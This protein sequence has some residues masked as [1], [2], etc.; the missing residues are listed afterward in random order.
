MKLLRKCAMT[1]TVMCAASSATAQYY[2]YAAP[3]TLAA[4]PAQMRR[5]AYQ[6]GHYVPSAIPEA[7]GAPVPPPQAHHA[8]PV[9]DQAMGAPEGCATCNGGTGYYG[10]DFGACGDCCG[11]SWYAGFTALY[12]TRNKPN[13]YQ[14]SFDT[15]NPVGELILNVDTIDD[16]WQE[17]FE[18]RVGKYIGCNSAIELS[19]WTLDNFGGTATAADPPGVGSLNTPFDFRSLNFNGTPV[20]DLFDNSQAHRLTRNDEFHNI[21]VNFVHFPMVCNPCGRMQA[22]WFAGVRYINFRESWEFATSDNDPSFGVDP[23]GEAAYDIDVDNNLF[24]LQVGG[25]GSFN[26]TDCLSVYAAPRFGVFANYMEH[27]SRIDSGDGI[28]A[29]SISSD[30]TICSLLGQLDVGVNYQ[31]TQRLSVFGGYRVLAIS[32]VALADS[33]IPFLQDDLF[34]I[35]DIDHNSNLVLHGATA[36]LLFQ[37]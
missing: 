6:E 19:Y 13:P 1:A 32:G 12:M 10:G 16:D 7:H 34:G 9:Y 18:V 4:P 5:T 24:G 36:G 11:P 37:F 33:Q 17:G 3:A 30:E 29:L 26:I 31:V 28:S 25:R 20:T 8:S 23:T 22:N 21:E 15:T 27:D 2:P 35:A 14:V